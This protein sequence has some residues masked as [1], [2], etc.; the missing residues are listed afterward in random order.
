MIK[1]IALSFLAIL[2]LQA[3]ATPK[4]FVEAKKIAW[5]IYEK[6]PYDIYCGCPYTGNRF[7]L[8]ACGYTP[9][10]QP[11]RAARVEWEHIVP[12]WVIGHQMQCWQEGGRENCTKH[13]P[14]FS[15]AEGDLHNLAPSV[16]EV[17]GDRSNFGFGMLPTKPYQYGACPM[18]VDFK[19]RTAMP[20]ENIRGMVARTYFYMANRYKLRL[21]KKDIQLYT[22]WSKQYPVNQYERWRNYENT[23]AMGW[24]NPYV[25]QVPLSS[26]K[27]KS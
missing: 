16:G 22:A 27:G 14:R 20:P 15:A 18:V 23:C 7:D 8:E 25:E 3:Q 1:V 10:K 6:A 5:K 17:N 11:A 26:C 19:Q 4:T 24:S 21:S 9:R 13:D 12:A 2:T